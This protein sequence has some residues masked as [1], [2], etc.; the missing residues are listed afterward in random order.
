[1]NQKGR[2]FSGLHAI[3][4]R[5]LQKREWGQIIKTLFTRKEFEFYSKYNRNLFKEFKIENN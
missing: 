2:W 5:N 1:M 4:G 3:N